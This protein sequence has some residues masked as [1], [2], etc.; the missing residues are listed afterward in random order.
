MHF[1]TIE[2]WELLSEPHIKCI[3]IY[4][5]IQNNDCPNIFQETPLFHHLGDVVSFIFRFMGNYRPL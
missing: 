5:L 4:V 1:L 2:N 3:F